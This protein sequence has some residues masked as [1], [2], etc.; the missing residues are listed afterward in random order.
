MIVLN[1][2]GAGPRVPTLLEALKRTFQPFTMQGK[3]KRFYSRA[4]PSGREVISLQ[5]VDSLPVLVNVR[6]AKMVSE[7]LGTG[8][9]IQVHLNQYTQI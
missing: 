1:N 5:N 9:W 4:G 2:I 8:I 7:I 3:L 6:G